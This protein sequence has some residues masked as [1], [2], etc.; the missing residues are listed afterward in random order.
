HLMAGTL[1]SATVG[2]LSLFAGNVVPA[3][4]FGHV[5]RTWWLGD[6]SGAMIVVPLALAFAPASPRF[7][8]RDR[9]AEATLVLAALI[10]LSLIAVQGGPPLSYLAFPALI[11]AALRFGPA[12]AAVAFGISAAFTVWDTT[13]SLGPFALQSINHSLLSA[14]VYLAVAGLTA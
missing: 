1:I 14:Q 10:T 3:G 9:L 6:F 13:H 7:S 11:W 12:G 2:T 5:W 8:L 4:S